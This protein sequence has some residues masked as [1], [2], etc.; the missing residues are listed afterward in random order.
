MVH[1]ACQR[2]KLWAGRSC[3]MLVRGI[4][5][6]K[7]NLFYF[8]FISSLS[9]TG[10]TGPHGCRCVAIQLKT[11]L[12]RRERRRLCALSTDNSVSAILILRFLLLLEKGV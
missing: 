1:R 9:Y 2:Q 8:N 3:A 4:G 5:D 7:N 11:Y 10:K 6:I 12:S